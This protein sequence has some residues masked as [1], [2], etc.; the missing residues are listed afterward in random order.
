MRL[1]GADLNGQR[2]AAAVRQQVDL[3]APAAAGAA[4]GVVDRADFFP[5]TARLRP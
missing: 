4:Q 5:V 3:A 2:Q 1:P